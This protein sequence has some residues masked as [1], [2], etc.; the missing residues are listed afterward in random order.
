M[1]ICNV[2]EYHYPEV[3][4]GSAKL[5]EELT[6]TLNKYHSILAVDRSGARSHS[7]LSFR[8]LLKIRKFRPDLIIVHHP[9]A[10]VYFRLFFPRTPLKLFFHGPWHLEYAIRTTKRG[11]TYLTKRYLQKLACIW[12]VEVLVLSAYMSEYAK[13][14]GAQRTKIL[15]PIHKGQHTKIISKPRRSS[16]QTINIV[17][18]R[19]LDK[20]TGVLELAHKVLQNENLILKIIGDGPEKDR[21]END[22]KTA[23]NIQLIPKVDDSEFDNIYEWC[24]V[25]ILPTI[26][27]EGFGLVI[28]DAFYRSKPI[29]ISNRAKGSVEYIKEILPYLIYDLDVNSK[30]L[31]LLMREA[32]EKFQEEDEKNKVKNFLKSNIIDEKILQICS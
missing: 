4:G 32:I 30:V 1:R 7:Y 27:Y 5:S 16:G 17:C 28:L 14:L 10:A 18:M 8:T 15:G 22:I 9:T 24:D 3:I 12:S 21:L 20:R 13:S 31:E 23:K 25:A 29:L 11:I 26:D 6:E 19:R 2:Q